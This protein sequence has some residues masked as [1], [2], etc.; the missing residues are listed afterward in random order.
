MTMK[1]ITGAIGAAALLFAGSAAAQDKIVLGMSG[2][3]G[4]APLSLAAEAGL[5]KKHGVDV[6]IKFIPQ[7]ERHLTVAS[8]STQAV[9]TTVDTFVAWTSAGIPLTQVLLLDKSKGGDGLAV[10]SQYNKITDLKGKTIAVDGAGTTPHFTLM[11]FM[12]RNGMSVKDVQYATLGPGPAAQAFVAG[13][14]DAALTYEPYLSQVRNAPNAGKII[15]TTLDYPCVVDMV[16]FQPDFI[17]KNPKIV[18]GVVNGFFDALEMIKREPDKSYEI[19]GSKV[20]QS[21]AD[22]AKSASYIAWQDKAANQAY[23]KGE[24]QAFMKEAAEIQLEAGVIKKIP[25]L[26]PMVDDSFIK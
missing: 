8:G 17:K 18:Q 1:I 26:G 21:G 6:E 2:W 10:R 5:F 7:K 12:K 4:F 14:Y 25:D 15:L 13:Q 24:L 19:M 3:T 16:A 11:V 22:F 20:K 9:A 23:F